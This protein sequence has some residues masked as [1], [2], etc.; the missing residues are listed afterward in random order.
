MRRPGERIRRTRFLP[1]ARLNVAE[2][3]LGPVSDDIA[4]IFRGEDGEA[5]TSPGPSCTT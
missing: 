5:P 4:V 1:D 3:L 2:N